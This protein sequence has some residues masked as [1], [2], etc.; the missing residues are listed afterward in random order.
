VAILLTTL[1]IATRL[2][3]VLIVPT[4]PVGDFAM[5]L[6][7]AAHL[8][9]HGGLDP[10]F[11]YMPGYVLAVA[12]LQWLGGGLLAAKL[13]GVAAGGLGTA[14]VYGI[15]LRLFDRASAL[16]AGLLCALWPA[17][18]A[19]ASVTGTDMPTAALLMTAV[20]LLLRDAGTRPVRAAVLFGFV[21]G[22][23]AYVRAV[24]LPLAVLAAPVWWGLR[25]PW[26]PLVQRTALSV[27]IAFL[28]LLPWGV[29]NKLHYGEFFLTDSHGG[30]TALVGANPNTE[31]VYS[32]SLNLM[33]SKGTGYALFAPPHRDADR[34]AYALARRWTAFEPDYALG[35]LPA[36][37]DRLLTHERPLLYWPIY[38]QS[39][40]SGGSQEWFARHQTGLERLV[41]VF[42]YTLVGAALVG[43]MI[44]ASRRFWPALAL[45]PFP[46]ALAAIYVVFFAEVRYHLA[47]AIFLFPYAGL[48]WRW[49]GQG[50]RDLSSRRFNARG[51]RRL[52]RE[53]A[54]GAAAVIAVFVGWPRLVSAGAE[55]RERHRWAVCVCRID[56]HERLC[57]WRPTIPASGEGASPVRGVWN[58]V[59]LKLSTAMAGAATDVA[60]PPGRYR[61]SVIA[62]TTV[63]APAPEIRLELRARGATVASANLPLAPG[64][65]PAR[66]EGVIA[67]Q[68]GELRVELHAE[69]LWIAPV[70]YDLPPLWIS[71]IKIEADIL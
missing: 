59:G 29:R 39:V 14:A 10:E 27:V 25:T 8:A 11:I 2:L 51:R 69:R 26:R 55:L 61:V 12:G 37:A 20:W 56:G 6:E 9:E 17:G 16:A 65:P 21:L 19:V 28:T 30:H 23:T 15:A 36:K 22:L 40:L 47:I 58:G 7:S 35:L 5:Y 64:A 32:R 42:W 34:A 52:L 38:R 41:D 60:L 68:G 3:W 24:A 1:A 70:F 63:S 43:V 62:D 31:G 57:E 54:L 49:V 48:A 71:D 33:F 45:L 46:L 13:L 53:A 50:V 4:H 66:V 67:H 44:A 18:I